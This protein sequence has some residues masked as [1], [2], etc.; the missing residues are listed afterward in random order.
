MKPRIIPIDVPAESKLGALLSNAYFYDC[1][2][3]VR[4]FEAKSVLELYLDGLSRTPAWVNVLMSLRN[5]IVALFGLKDLGTPGG[6]RTGQAGQRLPGGRQA[7]H[8]LHPA[9]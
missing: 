4:E 6:V 3:L 2:E 5:R 9:S 8:F 7:R 1:Y